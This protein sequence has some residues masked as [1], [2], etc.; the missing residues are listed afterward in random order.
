VVA[1]GGILN[2]ALRDLLGAVRASF[3]FGDTAFARLTVARDRDH[4]LLH[5]VNLQ[6][7]LV[8]S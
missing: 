2:M 8:I 3:V 1:H 6:P 4:G 7:H 5:G